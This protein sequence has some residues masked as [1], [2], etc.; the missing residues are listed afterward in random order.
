MPKRRSGNKL[1]YFLKKKRCLIKTTSKT[2]ISEKFKKLLFFDLV[3]YF[4]PK[5]HLFSFIWNICR[6]IFFIFIF[7]CS[8]WNSSLFGLTSFPSL[9]SLFCVSIQELCFF[10]SEKKEVLLK[11]WENANKEIWKNLS[12]SFCPSF[13]KKETFFK[14]RWKIHFLKRPEN[15][16]MNVEGTIFENFP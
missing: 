5:N 1:V 4:P 16:K 10:W 11:T 3:L 15:Q 9:F 14:K 2:H 13:T 8:F 7:C 12:F 6:N